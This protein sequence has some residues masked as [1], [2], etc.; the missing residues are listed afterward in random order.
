LD[1]IDFD[2]GAAGA[3]SMWPSRS[4]ATS[5]GVAGGRSHCTGTG[6]ALRAP[7]WSEGA[8]TAELGRIL[9]SDCWKQSMAN[10]GA[11]MLDSGRPSQ[12]IT[13]TMQRSFLAATGL[14]RLSD[15]SL[16]M[17]DEIWLLAAA[18]NKEVCG[19]VGLPMRHWSRLCPKAIFE[20]NWASEWSSPM[21]HPVADRTCMHPPKH[22]RVRA[23]TTAK[24][25]ALVVAFAL[26]VFWS[27]V[28]NT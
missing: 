28:I 7:V 10:A 18:V 2:G 9:S 11:I 17:L 27:H 20:N 19:A 26:S 4:K 14:Q 22:A 24:R 16:G 21:T 3:G 1:G 5:D 8:D 12:T 25:L 23:S 6:A 13:S 15:V